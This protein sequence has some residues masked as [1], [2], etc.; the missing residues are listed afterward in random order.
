MIFEEK[1][2]RDKKKSA[3]ISPKICFQRAEIEIGHKWLKE[4][5]VVLFTGE[6]VN[7]KVVI[8]SL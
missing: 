5:D 8:S 7:L 2:R 3:E 6:P 1:F 4:K